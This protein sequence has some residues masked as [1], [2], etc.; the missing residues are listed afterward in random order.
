MIIIQRVCE[1]IIKIMLIKN[2]FYMDITSI[3]TNKLGTG[4]MQKNPRNYQI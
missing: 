4:R 2:E 1:E 3:L